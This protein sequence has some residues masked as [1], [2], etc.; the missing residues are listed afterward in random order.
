[1]MCQWYTCQDDDDTKS[2]DE[3]DGLGQ[4]WIGDLLVDVT[5]ADYR[6]EE[7]GGWQT[8]T[9]EPGKAVSRPYL[10]KTTFWICLPT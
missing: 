9:I 7:Q 8:A 2:N 6:R 10:R 4:S 3:P 5:E 1:M